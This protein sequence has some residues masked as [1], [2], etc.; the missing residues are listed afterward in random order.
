[1]AA[2]RRGRK[3]AAD[4]LKSWQ[5]QR[6]Q[7]GNPTGRPPRVSLKDLVNQALDEPSDLEL[8]GVT[9]LNVLARVIADEMLQK[10]QGGHAER[11]LYMEREWPVVRHHRI[12]PDLPYPDLSYLTDEELRS[13]TA[14]L[15][16]ARER[17]EAQEGDDGVEIDE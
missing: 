7:S 12:A 3:G 15:D 1:M 14:I 16:K 9:K 17:S 11:K 10:T 6:G 4:H 5:W 13:V 8:P 2:R